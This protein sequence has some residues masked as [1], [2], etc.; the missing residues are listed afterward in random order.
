MKCALALYTGGCTRA[1]ARRGNGRIVGAHNRTRVCM[2][3]VAAACTPIPIQY[4]H[5]QVHTYLHIHVY[6]IHIYTYIYIYIHTTRLSYTQLYL[7][8]DARACEDHKSAHT[9]AR[10]S[11]APPR[12]TARAASTTRRT[13]PARGGAL[14]GPEAAHTSANEVTRA[15]FHAPMFALNAD[16]YWN[17]CEPSHPRSTPTEGA[18]MC[19]RGYMRAQSHAHAR[20]RARTQQVDACVRRSRMGD[21]FIL[22]ASRKKVDTCMHHVSICNVCACSIDSVTKR[23]CRTRTHAAYENRQIPLVI[24]RVCIGDAGTNQHI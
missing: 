21:P 13:R 9:R 24:A 4:I 10:A 6:C 22:V 8:V 14:P 16:A 7:H 12:T 20:A 1:C 3:G 23:A 19:R 11:A 15:V 18:R 2:G 17:A 5:I